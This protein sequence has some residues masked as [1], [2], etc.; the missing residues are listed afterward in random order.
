LPPSPDIAVGGRQFSATIA[1]HRDQ[2]ESLAEAW[3]GIG[4]S[5]FGIWSEGSCL[6]SWPFPDV[7]SSRYMAAPI[8]GSPGGATEVRVEI[9]PNTALERRLTADASLLSALIAAEA[10]ADMVTGELV[11]TQDQLVAVYDVVRTFAGIIDVPSV[12]KLIS[13]KSCEIIGASAG[14]AICQPGEARP[15]LAQCPPGF[16]REDELLE[17]FQMVQASGSELVVGPGQASILPRGADNIVILPMSVSGRV[18]AGLGLINSRRGPFSSPQLKLAEAI[19]RQGAAKME[20]ILLYQERLQQ[21][22][23]M[24]EMDLARR[25]QSSWFDRIPPLVDGLNLYGA[26]KPALNTGGDFYDFLRTPD[27]S[28]VFALGDVSGKG[29]SSAM[30]MSMARVLTRNAAAKRSGATP[31]GIVNRL[32][33]DLYGEL[34]DLGMFVTVFVGQYNADTRSVSYVNAGQSPVLYRPAGGEIRLIEA[35]CIPVGVLP[36]V[37]PVQRSLSLAPGDLLIIASDG[38]NEAHDESEEMFG[39]NRLASTVSALSHLSASEIARAMLAAVEEFSRGHPQDDDQTII[40][41]KG[42]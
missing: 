26:C 2:I 25:I 38:F 20:S 12:L 39:I 7:P 41:L 8:D 11:E 27:G 36:D 22:R 31:E 40:V 37:E 9:D 14:F 3:L 23:I 29:L 30:V 21:T 6:A 10:D 35:D 5:G 42:V 13:S 24:A 1:R 18:I 4:A 34:T 33:A 32:S 28:F 17:L 19:A 15:E 16:T